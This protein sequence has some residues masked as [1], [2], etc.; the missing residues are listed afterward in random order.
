M[1]Y[2]DSLI[3]IFKHFTNL[4]PEGIW[5]AMSSSNLLICVYGYLVYRSNKW[6]RKVL[7]A[8]INTSCPYV[9]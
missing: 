7:K 9:G 5:I 3:Q 4:G 6:Q 8:E 2:K 1:V